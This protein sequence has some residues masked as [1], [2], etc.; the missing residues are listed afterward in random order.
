MDEPFTC[1]CQMKT[2]LENSADVFAFLKENYP[3]PGIVDN[4]N[5]LSNKELCCVCY[6]M[7]GCFTEHLPKEDDLGLAGNKGIMVCMK[8]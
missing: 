6:L 2:D 5:K 8:I 3:L 1:T 7:G 4:L